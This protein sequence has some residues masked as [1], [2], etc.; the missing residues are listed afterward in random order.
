MSRDTQSPADG[1]HRSY[2]AKIFLRQRSKVA[3]ASKL[4]NATP[5]SCCCMRNNSVFV[6]EKHNIMENVR[7]RMLVDTVASSIDDQD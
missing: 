6:L 5:K 3:K 2:G 7:V 1:Y 4:T